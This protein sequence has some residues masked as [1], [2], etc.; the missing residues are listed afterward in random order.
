MCKEKAYK[1]PWIDASMSNLT[2]PGDRSVD[3]D[4]VARLDP[5]AQA[6]IGQQ[7]KTLYGRIVEESVPQHLLDLLEE[8]ERQEKAGEKPK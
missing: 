8:L 7:L 1:N 5:A 3:A 4:N 6:L 2:E